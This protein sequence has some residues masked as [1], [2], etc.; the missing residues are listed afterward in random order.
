MTRIKMPRKFLDPTPSASQ[1]RAE[2]VAQRLKEEED[3]EHVYLL[4][5]VHE[6]GSGRNPI[7]VYKTK[8]EALRAAASLV[9]GNAFR[10]VLRSIHEEYCQP[11]RCGCAC[12][13]T[14]VCGSIHDP[15]NNDCNHQ[16]WPHPNNE[17]HKW[18]FFGDITERQLLEL[19]QHEKYPELFD[20]WNNFWGDLRQCIVDD[21]EDPDDRGDFQLQI[22]RYPFG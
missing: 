15:E 22:S 1:E 12:H 19:Y 11:H 2:R 4:S 13:M 7:S 5:W 17:C 10:S 20:L 3:R 21:D 9:M 14:C 16:P 8:S 6:E 18:E